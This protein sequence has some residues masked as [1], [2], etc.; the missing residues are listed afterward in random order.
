MLGETRN[1][2]TFFAMTI[3]SG[4]FYELVKG[5]NNV[6]SIKDV[7]DGVQV[8]GTFTGTYECESN[9]RQCEIK[10]KYRMTLNVVSSNNPL[11]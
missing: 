1:T 3:S 8:E 6:K 7:G 2:C 9:N 11:D 5:T 4:E 10:G